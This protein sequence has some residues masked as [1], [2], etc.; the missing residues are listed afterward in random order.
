MKRSAPRRSQ[1]APQSHELT[2]PAL[3]SSVVLHLLIAAWV[4]SQVE[5]VSVR[6]LA[7]PGRGTRIVRVPERLIYVASPPAFRLPTRTKQSR[8]TGYRGLPKE[9]AATPTPQSSAGGGDGARPADTAAEPRS[10]VAVSPV[11]GLMPALAH[12]ALWRA[13]VVPS[14]AATPPPR[15]VCAAGS[16]DEW[17]CYA[18]EFR[19]RTDSI[20]RVLLRCRREVPIYLRAEECGTLQVP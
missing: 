4:L 14:L 2:W 9:A 17:S 1:R 7:A 20:A 6:V 13:V 3:A 15:P 8:G 11:R 19:W 18:R 5:R 16:R 10:G 12:P